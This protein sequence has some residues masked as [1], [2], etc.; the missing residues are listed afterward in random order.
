MFKLILHRRFIM[1]VAIAAT[2][3]AAG[4]PVASLAQEQSLQI[5]EIIVTAQKREQS[6]QDVPISVTALGADALKASRIENILDLQF[7]APNMMINANRNYT[8][9]G[10]GTQVYGGSRDA[11]V[12]YLVN[13][14]FIQAPD[15][16]TEMYDLERVEVLRGPQGTLMGR[17][18]T[19]GAINFITA[20]AHDE[21]EAS[22]ELQVEENNG[23]RFNGVLNFQLSDSISQRFAV[24]TLKRDGY[25]KNLLTGNDIDGR[26]Q[27]AIRSSTHF[28]FSDATS[29]DLV[30]DYYTED[31]TRNFSPKALCLPDSKYVCSPDAR[32]TDFP[33]VNYAITNLF[34]N[35]AAVVADKF[36]QNP[37]NLREVFMDTEPTHNGDQLIATFELNH[38]F[39]NHTFTSVTGYQERTRDTLR[40]FDLGAAPNAFIPGD[41][42]N[43]FGAPFTIDDDG[44]GNGV[45][46]YLEGGKI[47]TSTSYKTS[48]TSHQEPDQWSQEFRLTSD[49]DGKFNYVLGAYY[50][51]AT[52]VADVFTYLPSGRTAGGVAGDTVGYTESLA[53][54]GEV[55]WDVTDTLEITAGL[56]RSDEDKAISTGSWFYSAPPPKD[57]YCKAEESF[58]ETTGRFVA[59]W[60]PELS[61]GSDSSF[62]AS[63]S[64]GYKAGGFNPGNGCADALLSEKVQSFEIGTKN[65][66]LD[67]RLQLNAAVFDYS[68]DNL[69]LGAIVGGLAR[70]TNIPKSSVSGAELELIYLPNDKWRLETAVGFLS[71]E[72]DSEFLTDDA[73]R[74][75][76]TFNLKG[77][78]LPNSPDTTFKVAAQYNTELGNGWWVTPR[79]DYYWQDEFYTREYNTGAD[80]VDAWSQLDLT[81]SFR[82]DGSPW[83][84]TLFVK[85]IQDEDSITHVE[86]NSDLVGSF[87]SI[88]L[89]DPRT[90]GLSARY[91]FN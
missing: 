42:A 51:D 89:L 1:A 4:L 62:Y 37:S 21:F 68:Y 63:Y 72:I 13:G 29:A 11:G 43:I 8:I 77:R 32:A 46:T 84:V 82:K 58:S 7:N 14:V 57:S 44:N 33:E 69:T 64:T 59:N 2:S 25:T 38:D 20:R 18:T 15:E 65:V 36:I 74:N 88:F 50:L 23:Y 76:E 71:T 30:L 79:I 78:E 83:D 35:N 9:R 26:D 85:N 70:N 12:G 67:N 90:I 19:G 17:N 49:R 6:L 81:V 28:E 41:Y 24:N 48:Q 47:I 31:S 73:S 27:Q 10:V 40:D 39:G 60:S 66:L 91:T 5:E 56:R 16:S 86:T 75:F 87:K 22:A 34:L 52:W 45:L 53:F 3:L 80:T 54:F 61:S 55:Y